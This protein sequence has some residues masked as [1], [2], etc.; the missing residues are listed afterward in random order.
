MPFT[1]QQRPQLGAIFPEGVCDWSKKG[2]KQVKASTWA[3]YG[4]SPV[5]LLF[6]VTGQHRHHNHH[7]HD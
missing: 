1:P 6:D 3:S 4:P 2:V 5:N 7:H